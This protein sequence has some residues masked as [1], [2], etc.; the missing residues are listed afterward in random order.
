MSQPYR[1]AVGTIFTESN[2]LV[3]TFTDL[4]CFERTEL[5]RG[6]QVLESTDG[7]VGG[8]LSALRERGADIVPLLVATAVPGGIL[9]RDCYLTLKTEL[10][11]RLRDSK[12][13][14]GVLLPLH[15]GAAVEEIGDLEGDLV[16][17][18]RNEVGAEIPIVGTLD[19]HAHV[20]ERMVECT[21]ALVAWET[22]PHRDTYTTGVRGV[23]M[24]LD[25]LDGKVRPAMAMAKVPVIVG[26]IMG[27]TEGSAPFADVMRFAKAM[28]QRPDVLSTSTFLVQPYLDH[29]GMGGGGLVI[30]DGDITAAVELSTQVAE[31]YWERRF[32]LEPQVWS[33]R[34][35]IV[36]GLEMEGGPVLLLETADSVGGGAAGDSVAT[37]RAL[38]EN[39]ISVPA[40]VPVVDPEAAAKCHQETEG[41]E[42]RL[43]LGHR[44]DPRW[45]RAM[46]V[47]GRI[48][49]LTDGKFVYSGGIWGG[50]VAD[51]GPS[52]RLR[53]GS[54]EVL[55]CT[56]PTYD[57]ADEQY[58]SVGMDTRNAKFIVVKNPMNYRVGYEG[59]F[60][61]ALVLDTP[62]PTPA[63]L[64]HVRYTELKGP[65]FPAQDEIPG[66]RPVVLRREP[67]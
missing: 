60:T 27:S 33:P 53:I 2:H 35:A 1:I 16:E 29:P 44:V 36:R 63:I 52:V 4:A 66:L 3:G 8:M 39:F 26:G 22:Y 62:G 11:Q 14:G 59:K 56:F 50:Q 38:L 15:G 6:Q 32:D 20:S 54:V 45:G 34:E 58:R 25:I 51:M 47:T 17:A 10:L 55:I 42:I 31:M 64:R 21:D 67:R 19:L 30:T 41:S 28:E 7:V 61:E 18:V 49:K 40:L 65:Y 24:L 37:L 46:S 13:V 48:E 12:P 9:S 5:R 43:T 57:W 23:R